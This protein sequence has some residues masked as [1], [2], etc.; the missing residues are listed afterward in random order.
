MAITW[1]TATLANGLRVVTTP[2]P[3]AQSVSLNLFVGVGSR[4]E[5]QPTHGCSH[6]LEHMLF[7]GTTRWPDA[8]TLAQ[9]IEGAGGS[10]NAYTTKELTCYWNHVPSDCFTI[11]IEVLADMVR[12]SLLAQEE[13]ERE[14]TVIQQEIKRSQD[15]P[16]AWAAELLSRA[17]FGDQ[18]LGWSIAGSI[19]TVAEIQRANLLQH[20]ETWYVPNNM[21]LSVAGNITHAA[22]VAAAERLFGDM[23]PRSVPAFRLASPELPPEHILIEQRSNAQCNLAVGV[24]AFARRDPDRYVAIIVNAILGRGMSSRLF[25]EVR[26]RRGLAYSIGSSFARYMD[27]GLFSVSAGVSP[28][29][30]DEA[31][32]VILAEL[33]KLTHELVAEDE[34]KKAIDYSVGSFRLGLESTMA[35]GQRA[36]EAL[37]T[38]GEIEPIEAV[39]EQLRSVTAEDIRRVAQRIFRRGCM[40]LSLVG[41]YQG[42]NAIETL[43]SAP[44]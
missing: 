22:V 5:D 43:L 11:A 6:F 15:Q 4:S 2:V 9:T 31:L 17:A 39:V 1:E 30:V 29:R 44:A 26:E 20:V 21:V 10:L 37:L 32:A 16:G 27:T 23:V 28:E 36:G 3:T 25:R 7:K 41:P 40:A 34:L 18:P 14:R 24:H 33:F 38:M 35:L 19:E 12:H 8:I 42:E 13:V